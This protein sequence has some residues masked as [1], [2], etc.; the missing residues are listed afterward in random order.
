MASEIED[1]IED[2][3]EG[4]V[5]MVLIRIPDGSSIFSL[6]QVEYLTFLDGPAWPEGATITCPKQTIDRMC[7]KIDSALSDAPIDFGTLHESMEWVQIFDSIFTGKSCHRSQ[8]MEALL[9]RKIP[10]EVCEFLNRAGTKLSFFGALGQLRKLA[11]DCDCEDESCLQTFDTLKR[12]RESKEFTEFDFW[13]LVNLSKVSLARI[14][15]LMC[16]HGSWDRVCE[17]QSFIDEFERFHKIPIESMYF[18]V[19]PKTQCL[20][21][22]RGGNVDVLEH[23]LDSIYDPTNFD[24]G[25]S[26]A[27]YSPSTEDHVFSDSLIAQVCRDGKVS[28]LEAMLS[29]MHA[30]R[31][32]PVFNVRSIA[33]SK[34]W[35][36]KIV[37][38]L[39]RFGVF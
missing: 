38:C 17:A 24:V 35:D 3:I 18:Y 7:P 13:N 22:I 21:A 31:L 36:S 25:A 33:S 28:L 1:R 2:R 32:K 5:R 26:M 11:L 12:L 34:D 14:L 9:Y 6:K 10:E 8:S 20:Y 23:L 30:G 4:R 15:E 37:E 19:S 39:T 16:Q 27:T 29:R